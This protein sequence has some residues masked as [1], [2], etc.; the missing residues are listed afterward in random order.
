MPFPYLDSNRNFFTIYGSTEK[1]QNVFYHNG[2]SIRGAPW[3]QTAGQRNGA[4]SWRPVVR[5][6]KEDRPIPARPYPELCT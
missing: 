3:S 1:L 4:F 2:G 6:L 5:P